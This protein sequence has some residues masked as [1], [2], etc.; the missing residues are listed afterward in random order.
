MTFEE[1]ESQAEAIWAQGPRS[2]MVGTV[3]AHVVNPAIRNT[4][5]GLPVSRTLPLRAGGEVVRDGDRS[6]KVHA[7]GMRTDLR[8]RPIVATRED[9]KRV[10]AHYRVERE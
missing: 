3:Y 2:F 10:E 7:D 9:Q 6:I 1:R 8:G 4:H 5:N